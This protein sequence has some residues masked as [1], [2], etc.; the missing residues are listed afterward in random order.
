MLVLLF[1]LGLGTWVSS[2]EAARIT[3]GPYLQELGPGGVVVR[4]EVDPPSPV[5]LVIN[6]ADDAEPAG[7]DGGAPRAK[8]DAGKLNT[9]GIVEAPH[10]SALHDLRVQGLAPQRRYTYEITVGTGS[11]TTEKAQGTFTTSPTP[12]TGAP[13]S[14]LLYGDNRTDPD[15]HSAVVRAMQNV[16]SD[17]LVHTGDFIEDGRVPADWQEFFKI[18]RPLLRDRCVFACVGN[19]ELLETAGEN[20]L[21]Y[22]GPSQPSRLYSSFR[23]GDARFFLLNGSDTFTDG[24]EADWLKQ[25]LSRADSEAGL[26]WRFVVIHH[27]PW[28][29]GPHGNN[30][31]LLTGNAEALFAQHKIDAI[32]SGHD[33]IYERGSKN[34]MRYVVSGGGGAPLYPIKGPSSSTRKVESAYHFVEVSVTPDAVKMIVHRPTGAVLE[35][36]GFSRAPGW[37]CD[38][39]TAPPLL[40]ANAP[41]IGSA[42]PAPAEPRAP[43]S[44]CGCRIVGDRA[45][46]GPFAPA[47][48]LMVA[49]ALGARRGTRT[50]RFAGR[51]RP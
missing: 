25:E 1:A 51:S 26:S 47:A 8:P 4:I 42:A 16:P 19:H 23:W 30:A 14:F 48:L 36:C 5:T 10:A 31:R 35:R 28:S 20:Y 11:A 39:P 34:G 17:F 13:F 9:V 33:H 27:G 22:F 46:R 43:V 18:E 3:K 49:L 32:F 24:A 21:R 29:A 50:A 44:R 7:L 38:A 40:P 41:A 12:G 6:A 37:D 15:A 45:P 2:A